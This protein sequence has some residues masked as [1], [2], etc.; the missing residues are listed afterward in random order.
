MELYKANIG[1][2]KTVVDLHYYNL[3]DAFFNNLSA[4]DNIQFVYNNRQPQVQ[5]LNNANGP[6]VFIGKILEFE[7]YALRLQFL[8]LS[9]NGNPLN[10]GNA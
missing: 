3:F 4:T 8:P 5:T 2:V 1:D 9:L 6:L 10:Y 7:L